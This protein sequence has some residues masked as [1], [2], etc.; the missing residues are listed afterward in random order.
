MAD[1]SFSMLWEN[2]DF[3]LHK[4]K[5][6]LKATEKVSDDV[7]PLN[8]TLDTLIGLAMHQVKVTRKHL[9]EL[10]KHHYGVKKEPEKAEA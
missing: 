4:L 10:H 9:Q 2:V 8:E 7:E 5:H 6:I 3:S 1:T